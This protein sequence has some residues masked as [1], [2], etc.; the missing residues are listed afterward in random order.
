MICKHCDLSRLLFEKKD[1]GYVCKNCG[2]SITKEQ[3]DNIIFQ[4]FEMKHINS[5]IRMSPINNKKIM[6]KALSRAGIPYSN[7]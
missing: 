1:N 3:L 4:V 7:S 5:P 6:E 2:M